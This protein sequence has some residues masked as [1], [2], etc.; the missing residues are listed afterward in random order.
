MDINKAR[1]LITLVGVERSI[2]AIAHRLQ[3]CNPIIPID[4]CMQLAKDLIKSIKTS[5]PYVHKG[6]DIYKSYS[7]TYPAFYFGEQE[8]ILN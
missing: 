5:I 4:H 1:E 8:I 6:D 3:Q 7:L 2:E